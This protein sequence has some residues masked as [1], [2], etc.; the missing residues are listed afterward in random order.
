MCSELTPTALVVDEDEIVRTA[1]TTLLAGQGLL[2]RV[3]GT[4]A[5]AL[6]A[7][8]DG[9]VDVVVANVRLPDTTGEALLRAIRVQDA[10]LP[11]IFVTDWPDLGHRDGAGLVGAVTSAAG[12]HRIGRRG[13]RR[14]HSPLRGEP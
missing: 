2:V 8:A 10:A 6:A 13:R 14:T 7:L 1:C 5:A 11:V 9:E 12:G 4:C 3:A